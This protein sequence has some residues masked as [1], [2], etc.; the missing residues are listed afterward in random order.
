MHRTH[1]T[2]FSLFDLVIF[3]VQSFTTPGLIEVQKEE[4][5]SGEVSSFEII[6]RLK[7]LTI[8]LQVLDNILCF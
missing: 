4:I 8:I 5:T 3:L 6:T 1:K 7:L 2:S